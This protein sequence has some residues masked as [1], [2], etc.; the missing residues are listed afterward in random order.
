MCNLGLVK[1][2]I[3]GTDI[4]YLYYPI[5]KH[6]HLQ[7]KSGDMQMS[8]SWALNI[9]LNRGK[10]SACDSSSRHLLF[11]HLKK[12]S[13]TMW[14]C[15]PACLPA[16]SPHLRINT[17]SILSSHSNTCLPL[18]SKWI[19]FTDKISLEL[20]NNLELPAASSCCLGHI[21]SSA[22]LPG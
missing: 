9:L 20:V 11:F 18:P 3:F 4:D 8:A 16:S 5:I 17:Q 15:L 1:G 2:K 19:N 22:P 6:N 12:L 13:S 21:L 7:N 10:C 14:Q